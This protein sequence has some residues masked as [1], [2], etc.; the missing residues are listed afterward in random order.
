VLGFRGVSGI[1]ER[2]FFQR[3]HETAEENT[4]MIVIERKRWG[5]KYINRDNKK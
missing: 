2:S 3:S 1:T 5:F 4:R